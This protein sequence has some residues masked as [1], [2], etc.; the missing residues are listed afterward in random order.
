MLAISQSTGRL[1]HALTAMSLQIKEK[2]QRHNSADKDDKT[3]TTQSPQEYGLIRSSVAVTLAQHM[4]FQDDQNECPEGLDETDSTES[5][6][7]NSSMLLDCTVKGRPTL[8]PIPWLP[9][10]AEPGPWSAPVDPNDALF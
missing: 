1:Y 6:A 4:V 7:S 8:V 10:E 5:R 2:K 3:L 9:L